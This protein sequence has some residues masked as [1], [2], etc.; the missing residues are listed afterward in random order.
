MFH[1]IFA[2]IIQPDSQFHTCRKEE[3]VVQILSALH[4]TSLEFLIP[5]TPHAADAVSSF[6]AD[7]DRKSNIHPVKFTS[8][9]L[10]NAPSVVGVLAGSPISRCLACLV[11]LDCPYKV[12]QS[13]YRYLNATPEISRL[14]CFR[15]ATGSPEKLLS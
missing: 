10:H 13:G 6:S 8:C 11:L 2:S 5:G 1:V 9:E 4:A 3:L 14:F 15:N 7:L 12:D